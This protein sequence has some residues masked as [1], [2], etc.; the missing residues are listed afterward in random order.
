MHSCTFVCYECKVSWVCSES[1]FSVMIFV[2]V[3]RLLGAGESE[4]ESEG[5]AGQ[6]TGA[7]R[8]LQEMFD[9]AE[10]PLGQ[11]P[12]QRASTEV[13]FERGRVTLKDC[14]A[15]CL[16]RHLLVSS[17]T[18]QLLPDPSLGFL[19]FAMLQS[20]WNPESLI[21]DSENSWPTVPPIIELVSSLYWLTH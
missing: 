7:A 20:Q 19:F 6:A 4:A 13:T 3:L 17:L 15:A 16:T 8:A 11:E 18:C 2:F 14:Q 9:T 10:C 21:M 1:C 5:G 12:K